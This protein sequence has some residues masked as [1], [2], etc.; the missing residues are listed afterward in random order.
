MTSHYTI[1]GTDIYGPGTFIDKEV[2]PVPVD[3]R[4]V[5][6]FLASSTPGFTQDRAAWD[7]VSFTGGSEPMIPGPIKAPV[8]AAALHAMC[9]LV[10]NELLELRDGTAVHEST[11][12]V[13]TDHAGLWLGSTFT[14][15]INGEGVSTLARSNALASL[16][17]RDFEQGFGKGLAGRATAIYQ[18]KDPNVWYQLH[19]SLDATRT[20]QSMGIPTDVKF[21]TMREYYDYIQ[22]YVIQWSP[23]ELEMHNVRHGLCGSICYSPEGW[24]RTT[25]GQRLAAHPLVNYTCATY[26]A[27]TPPVPLPKSPADRR[28]LAG[29]KVLEMVR[30]I[31]GPTIGVTLAS[32]GADVIRV[33]CSKLA[34]LN[35]LQLTLNAGKRTID[36]D[37]FKAE[38]MTRLLDLLAEADI[39]VQGFRPGSLARQGLDLNRMLERAATRNKG[40]IYVDENCYGPDGAFAERPGWQQIG[41]A[42]SGTVLPPLPVSDMTTGLV[43]ALAAMMAVRDRTTQGG[44]YHVVSSLV[45]ADAVTLEPEIGLYPPAVVARTAQRFGFVPATPDQFVSEIMIQVLDGWKQEFDRS[46]YGEEESRFM[47]VFEDGPWGRQA[48]LKPVARLGDVKASPRWSSPSVPNCYH[49]RDIRWF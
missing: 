28:P 43:G 31:A 32:Y 27:P 17:D 5:F 48:L 4:R 3:A 23:D 33:N 15:H 26:A 46:V 16:F 22:S 40:I 41:D 12:A 21:D 47:T 38:D 39:F 11:V 29:V 42:A 34:D 6:E 25:M 44:S 14:T 36:L 18:T 19:G 7:T 1:P 37:I 10:A 45:A 8:V 30:I 2:L 9:G 35:V 13:D 49:L 20:L 24:R